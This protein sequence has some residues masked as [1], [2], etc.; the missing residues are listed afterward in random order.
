MMRKVLISLI[1]FPITIILGIMEWLLKLAMKLSTVV[2]GLFFNVIIVCVI[3]A[4]CTKQW[5]SA[6]LLIIIAWR[7]LAAVYGNATLLY[8]I[9]EMRQC[10]TKLRGV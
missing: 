4:V 2:V 9:G 10:I 3:I 1:A 5:Q 7:G 6:G 8:L